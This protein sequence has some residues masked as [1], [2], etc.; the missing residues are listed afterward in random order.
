MV[1]LFLKK[2]CSSPQ[3]IIMSPVISGTMAGNTSGLFCILLLVLAG[4]IMVSGCTAGSPPVVTASPTQI[5]HRPVMTTASA[6]AQS[7]MTDDDCVPA[8]CCHPTSC[9]N[10]ANKG[11]CNL[12][13]TMSCE[14][15]I[16]CGAGSCGC[17]NGKCSVV[18]STSS[19]LPAVPKLP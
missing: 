12:L 8:Q 13:C 2:V 11:V 6:T 19:P 9:S 10:K 4:F 7:C 15:P 3:I 18:V 5:P 17:V 1:L 16:D 14:G